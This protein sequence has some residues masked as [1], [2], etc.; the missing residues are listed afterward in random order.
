[1]TVSRRGLLSALLG[2][3][4]AAPLV[5]TGCKEPTRA[6]AGE[7]RGAAHEVGHRLRE[8][9]Y[10]RASGDPERV[11]VAIVGAGPAGLSAGWRL[12]RSGYRDFRIFDLEPQAGGTSTYGTDGSVPYPWGAHYVPVPLEGNRALRILLDEMGV[13]TG[14][15]G[16]PTARER[17]R[18]R[19]PEERIFIDGRWHVGLFPAEG[20]SDQDWSELRR[21]EQRMDQWAGVRDASGRRAFALPLRRSSDDA[22]LVELDRLSAAD[23]FKQEGF[24][25]E[26]L[27]WYLELA[28]RDDYGLALTQTSAWA[29]LFYFC[30][31]RAHAD[32]ESQPFVSWSEGNG[33]LV[34]HL[35]RQCQG[36]IETGSLVTDVLPAEDQVRLA[37]FSA[38][39]GKLRPL[40]AE[41][42]IL[43]VP[44][45]VAARVLRPWRDAK[46]AHLQAF[47]YGP[48][49]V[50]NLHLR[51]EPKSSGAPLA[52]D[53]VL[54]DSPSLG[55]V[56][57]R[58]QALR[59]LG[60]DVWTYYLPLTG[61]DVR[62]DRERLLE[63]DHTTW[64]NAIV[65]D[66]S[67]A[68]PDLAEH[69]ERIDL[70][71]W[72]HAMVRPTPGFLLGAGR[73][74]ALGAQLDR[75]H[76]A[77]S[78]LSGIA[79]FE[80]AQDRGVLAAERALARLGRPAEPLATG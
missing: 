80:E 18:I 61:D 72:G 49:L 2:A 37:V 64:S 30:A 27:R 56:S 46:P 73:K 50:A 45:F 77:H 20:A 43:A 67:Q 15:P 44:Q 33:R 5:A 23:W 47:S 69:L 24:R 57:A 79:L 28:C 3:P 34:Q 66:L 60:P 35:A 7:V 10:E 6:F 78:D 4:L 1:M 25:S 41:H 8:A 19:E 65:G 55:Y 21:F 29:L 68:H 36:R 14:D 31:R 32:S 75:V 51:R 38:E 16:P 54:Y 13:L 52:W 74:A 58:H 9:W 39:T 11:G 59:D 53:N 63:N 17:F 12:A 48:W 40:H 76:F 70:Y 71:K 42:V 26:R 22:K 62:R